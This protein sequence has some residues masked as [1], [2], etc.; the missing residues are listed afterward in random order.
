MINGIRVKALISVP[1]NPVYEEKTLFVSN[2]PR[3]MTS[4]DLQNKLSELALLEVFAIPTPNARKRAAE[5]STDLHSNAKRH[6]TR[7][8]IETDDDLPSTSEP[9]SY[10]DSSSVLTEV[11]QSFETP[12]TQPP[13]EITQVRLLNKP[14]SQ[15]LYGYIETDSKASAVR[16]LEAS[17][18]HP[19]MFVFDGCPLTIAPS[20]PKRD[21]HHP[22]APKKQSQPTGTPSDDDNR[23]ARTLYVSNLPWKMT[24]DELVRLFGQFG[25]VA[26]TSL[27]T[28]PIRKNRNK[29]FAFIEY[30]N[31]LDCMTAMSSLDGYEIEGRGISVQQSSR[32]ITEPKETGTTKDFV[33]NSKESNPGPSEKSTAQSISRK[34]EVDLK[35]GGA[36][37]AA[38]TGKLKS[39]LQ[40]DD[41]SA[42]TKKELAAGSGKYV[43]ED[44]PNTN[45]EFRRKM[46]HH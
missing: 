31:Q 7:H 36:T 33:K 15:M 44:V 27:S 12:R 22:K 11:E 10:S 43:G 17:S 21:T 18:S 8:E 41:N 40:L 39:K 23:K 5:Y 3:H 20:V 1:K 37:S 35:G 2:V 16:L 13:W 28:D 9:H 29:G 42:L 24:E 34:A 46:L 32:P 45:E 6:R 4:K 30:V 26:K 25:T 38:T 19:S 14:Q